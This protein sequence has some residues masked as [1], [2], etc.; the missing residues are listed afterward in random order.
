MQT[1]VDNLNN[2]EDIDDPADDSY[3]RLNVLN[4]F[5]MCA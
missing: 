5:N 2:T 1:I 3:L 4:E